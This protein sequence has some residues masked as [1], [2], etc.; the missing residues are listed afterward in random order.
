MLR[1]LQ[2]QWYHGLVRLQ[3]VA[4]QGSDPWQLV[5]LLDQGG[6]C[7]HCHV[8]YDGNTQWNLNLRL[9][10]SDHTLKN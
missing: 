10:S 8:Q 4:S 5:L 6:I 9:I 7:Q 2:G 1:S 3:A